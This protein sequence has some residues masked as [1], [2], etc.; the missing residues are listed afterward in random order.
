MG[1]ITID[2][3][4]Y[5]CPSFNRSGGR[6]VRQRSAKPCTAVRFRFRPHF[7]FFPFARGFMSG[8][9]HAT[10]RSVYIKTGFQGRFIAKQ[11]NIMW[12]MLERHKTEKH[13]C[14][15]II[16]IFRQGMV[17]GKFDHHGM[18]GTVP[19]GAV[20]RD[21]AVADRPG[22]TKPDAVIFNINNSQSH[23]LDFV[24]WK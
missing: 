15:R 23:K 13:F 3:S 1:I 11:I 8:I 14:I 16:S 5:I 2:K 18:G 10:R 4:P 6:A 22:K 19:V 7:L 9:D 17:W 12:Q 20:E 24:T 21:L